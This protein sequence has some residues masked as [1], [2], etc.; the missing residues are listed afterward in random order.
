MVGMAQPDRGCESLSRDT[1]LPA[2]TVTASRKSLSV[3]AKLQSIYGGCTAEVWT[4]DW[5]LERYEATLSLPSLEPGWLRSSL[6]ANIAWAFDLKA[7]SVW[8][9]PDRKPSNNR[10]RV[11]RKLIES[12]RTDHALSLFHGVVPQTSYH[13]VQTF[14]SLKFLAH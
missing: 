1:G 10:E 4:R 9:R 6:T 2:N 3:R 7:S 13:L 11:R 5:P 12:A 14:L 8:L